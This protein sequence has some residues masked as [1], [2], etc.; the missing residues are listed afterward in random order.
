MQKLAMK[1]VTEISCLVTN[2]VL[3]THEQDGGRY[4]EM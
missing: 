2:V 4:D 1:T 3:M